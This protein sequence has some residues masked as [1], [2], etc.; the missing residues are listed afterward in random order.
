[1]TEG[2]YRQDQTGIEFDVPAGFTVLS[3]SNYPGN[4]GWLTTL[5]D[6]E[7]HI[8]SAWLTR[9][10]IASARI[11]AILDRE[12]PAKIKRRTGVDHYEVPPEGI[13][14]TMINEQQAGA[15]ATVQRCPPSPGLRV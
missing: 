3:T 5:G 6:A 8:F 4:T 2:R 14:K 13:Q 11:P 10:K 7:N 12:V 9:H 15:A 1:V